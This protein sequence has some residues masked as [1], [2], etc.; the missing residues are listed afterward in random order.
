MIAIVHSEESAKRLD[1]EWNENGIRKH[2]GK[3]FTHRIILFLYIKKSAEA[4]E[5]VLERKSFTL[6][7]TAA[8]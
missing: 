2:C 5:K 6:L 1:E 7:A 3:I 4:S 8:Y